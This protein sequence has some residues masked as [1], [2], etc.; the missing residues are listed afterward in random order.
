MPRPTREKRCTM[1][2]DH[3]DWLHTGTWSNESSLSSTPEPFEFGINHEASAVWERGECAG[4]STPPFFHFNVNPQYVTGMNVQQQ[5]H[6]QPLSIPPHGG[7]PVVNIRPSVL[8]PSF[9]SAPISSSQK[10]HYSS[11]SAAPY[12]QDAAHISPQS[13]GFNI[14]HGQPYLSQ[15]DQHNTPLKKRRRDVQMP[16]PGVRLDV[17]SKV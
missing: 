3:N 7:N 6:V 8:Y 14:S 5:P 1:N 11:F 17:L 12:R 16:N 15:Y 13:I 10:R 4:L 9:S 2:K